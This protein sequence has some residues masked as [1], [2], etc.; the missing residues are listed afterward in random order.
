MDRA[1][2]LKDAARRNAL[3]AMA[4]AAAAIGLPASSEAHKRR[5]E[6][7]GYNVIWLMSDETSPYALKHSGNAPRAITPNLDALAATA[8]QFT[9]AYTP[10]P[11]CV[12]ARQAFLS[13]RMASNLNITNIAN[14]LPEDRALTANFVGL[15]R[16]LQTLGGMKTAWFGK[17]HWGEGCEDP[18][19]GKDLS[20]LLRSEVTPDLTRETNAAQLA[21][22]RFKAATGDDH[23]LK[24]MTRYVQDAAISDTEVHIGWSTAYNEDTIVVDQALDFL[25]NNAGG[26]QAF[27]MGV[28]L[29]KPHFPFTIQKAYCRGEK[30]NFLDISLA[31]WP[32]PD[33]SQEMLNDL[34]T[35]AKM[36]RDAY[37]IPALNNQQRKRARAIY[38]GM[39]TY[40]DEQLGR[41][42]NWLNSNPTVRDKTIIIYTA[43]HGEMLGEHGTYYKNVFNE[44][45][46]RVPLLIWLP[47]GLRNGTP[48]S[49][50]HAPVSTLDLYPTICKLLKLDPPKAPNS[51][52]YYLE[53]KSVK[54]LLQNGNETAPR[55]VVSENTRNGI[56]ARMIRTPDYKY[57][58]YVCD[59][60]YTSQYYT[61]PPPHKLPEQLYEYKGRNPMQR[62]PEDINLAINATDENRLLID[63][64]LRPAAEKGWKWRDAT[65]STVEPQQT[66]SDPESTRAHAAHRH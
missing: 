3:K 20:D 13:G 49:H 52:A 64:T 17:T 22:D 8:T 38:Y 9:A 4:A 27:F 57:C 5:T 54:L 47:P 65:C 30:G 39:V 56:K 45:S 46:A 33:P 28:S 66:C 11:I 50:V 6:L 36:D 2:E 29:T 25:A 35:S 42:L 32:L 48:P 1:D 43:D 24:E 21:A 62:H 37:G 18:G 34:S 7:V 23:P 55:T 40:M 26:S 61:L 63:E 59:P 53:G 41:V 19:V 60:G 16:H 58:Y 31:D 12:P 15:P 44:D 10:N 14:A 51:G